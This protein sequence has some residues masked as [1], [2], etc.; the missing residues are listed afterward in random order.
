MAPCF[1]IYY[2]G[3]V[4][5]C[6]IEN[7]IRVYLI[8]QGCFNLVQLTLCASSICA[9]AKDKESS[10]SMCLGCVNLI[11]ILFFIAWT[12]AGSVWVWRS[13]SDWQDDHSV[14]NNAIIISAIIFLALHYVA[15]LLLCCCCTCLLCVACSKSDDE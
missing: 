14:C 13:L 11:L 9:S 15:I 10:L 5:E 7:N 8:V 2:V 12:I 4:N 6:S 1:H 3:A